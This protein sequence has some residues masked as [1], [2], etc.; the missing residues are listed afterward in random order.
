MASRRRGIGEGSVRERRP[1][2]W[3][4]R[5]TVGFDV[6]GRQVRRS[7]YG[8][9]RADVVAKMNEALRGL[10]V[11]VS[12]ASDRQTVGDFLSSWIDGETSIR[13]T[14]ARRYR[15]LIEHQL[16]PLLGRVKL[17]QLTPQQ[18]SLAMRRAAASG[19]APRT[20]N[21]AR[22]VLRSAL[23]D[24]QRWGTI[25]RNAAAL[26]EPLEVPQT[27]QAP[28]RPEE[29][30]AILDAFRGTDLEAVVGTALYLGMRQGEI[31]G[32]RWRDVDLERRVLRVTGALQRVPLNERQDPDVRST[33]VEPKTK[34]SRRS[35]R[36]PAPLVDL[37]AMQR[38]R[39]REDRLRLG[40]A[41]T[42]SISGLV[43]TRPTGYPMEPTGVTHRFE[44]GLRRAGLPVRRFHD[45]RHAAATLMLASGTE[46]KVVSAVLG[47]STIGITADTYAD[48][49]QE[50]HD[51]AADRLARF[52]G[53]AE[54]E[55][56]TSKRNRNTPLMKDF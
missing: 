7:L 8:K 35:L 39:Q 9:N 46:L 51:D 1:G 18:V 43:F 25:A 24:A 23:T 12:P 28:V 52:I 48:V 49:L 20:V 41:W 53:A 14:T 55:D 34:R 6:S 45:L 30:R 33:L 27:R 10:T 38:Q 40:A 22:A 16:I 44:E 29:A 26:A 4:A 5:V 15:G 17:A 19:L 3:E 11:G 13:P 31:L 56:S 50:L 21:H 2:Q 36:I 32:L 37:L 54:G 47:H 42:E